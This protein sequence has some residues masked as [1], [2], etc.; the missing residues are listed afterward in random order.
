MFSTGDVRTADEGADPQDFV[1][2]RSDSGSKIDKNAD[3]DCR[4]YEYCSTTSVFFQIT[5][6]ELW[7]VCLIS[8]L[9]SKMYY[10]AIVEAVVDANAHP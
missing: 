7:K 3:A 1:Q 5:A 8:A 4:G 6:N 10:K 2:T 9:F